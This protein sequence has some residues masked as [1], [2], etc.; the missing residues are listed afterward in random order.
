M[1]S[2][3]LHLNLWIILEGEKQHTS[4]QATPNLPLIQNY[5]SNVHI[6][7]LN[8]RKMYKNVTA[9]RLFVKQFLH[10]KWGSE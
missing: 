8:H 5:T 3:I 1:K 7:L 9:Y 2:K 4:I 10:F 6:I